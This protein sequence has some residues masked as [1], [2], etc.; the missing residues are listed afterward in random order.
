MDVLI[1][2]YL[3]A[4][5]TGHSKKLAEQASAKAALELMGQ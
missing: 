1:Y 4:E 5:C 3:L 2:C